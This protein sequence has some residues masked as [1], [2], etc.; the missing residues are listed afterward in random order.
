M[1]LKGLE[2][3][4]TVTVLSTLVRRFQKMS[5][6]SQRESSKWSVSDAKPGFSG[7][8]LESAPASLQ[9]IV[10]TALC[11]PGG[12]YNA[13]LP[14][15]ST[16]GAELPHIMARRRVPFQAPLRDCGYARSRHA[17]RPPELEWGPGP[18]RDMP[19]TLSPLA[20]VG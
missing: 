12:K 19:V 5:R 18:D 15:V 3:S 17:G 10:G 1:N 7:V 20:N 4:S 16:P 2:T 11:L 14:E 8:R 9:L 6:C 13:S